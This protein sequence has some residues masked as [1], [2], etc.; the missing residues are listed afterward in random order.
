MLRRS[1]GY[2]L[3]VNF[4]ILCKSGFSRPSRH[5]LA[6]SFWSVIHARPQAKI[7]SQLCNASTSVP[8]RLAPSALA[9]RMKTNKQISQDK[10]SIFTF[11]YI[12]IFLSGI[13]F[14]LQ[15]ETKIRKPKTRTKNNKWVEQRAHVKW[16]KSHDA[17][18]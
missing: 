9:L 4:F 1:R 8:H 16:T 13:I 12:F 14:L 18:A 11:I 7:L 15:N 17:S 3:V 6:L 2:R 10:F 5:A